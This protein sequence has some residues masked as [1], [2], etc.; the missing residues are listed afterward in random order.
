MPLPIFSNEY[1]YRLLAFATQEVIFETSNT[2]DWR[3]ICENRGQAN[4]Y[5]IICFL[6][7]IGAGSSGFATSRS[8]AYME[9]GFNWLPFIM[10]SEHDTARVTQGGTGA[11]LQGSIILYPYDNLG[12]KNYFR[13]VGGSPGGAGDWSKSGRGGV[14]FNTETSDSR[15]SNSGGDMILQ[16]RRGQDGNIVDLVRIRGGNGTNGGGVAVISPDREGLFKFD[17]TA[18][19]QNLVG[20]SGQTSSRDSGD[21]VSTSMPSSNSGRFDNYGVGGGGYA[22]AG[23]TRYGTVY[24]ETRSN[25]NVNAGTA[26]RIRLTFEDIYLG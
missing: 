2:V 15:G 16:G 3:V 18:P 1:D 5:P 25:G 26:G 13:V 21:N 7:G 22:Y 17:F 12:Q 10:Y 8:H 14:G 9:W 6:R 24:A 19:S 20:V 11:Y 4:D 23:A